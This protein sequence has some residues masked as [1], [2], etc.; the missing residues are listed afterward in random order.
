MTGVEELSAEAAAWAREQPR[1]R[2]AFVVGSQVRSATPADERSD[3]DVVLP[4][5]DPAALVEAPSW[6]ARFGSPEP[7]FVEATAVGG[8]RERCVLY[9]D[10]LEVDFAVFPA[11]AA[12]ALAASP[13]PASAV[14]R[15]YRVLHDEV[16]AAEAL[17]AATDE[18]PPRRAPSEIAHDFWYHAL[19]AAKKHRRGETATARGCLEGRLKPLRVELARELALLRDPRTDTWH[20]ARLL[21]RWADPRAVAASWLAARTPG[22]LPAALHR[23]CDAL[24]AELLP[25]DPGCAGARR[26]LSG[27]LP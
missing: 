16:G 15:G 14:R 13:E 9:A 2:A 12:E 17:A 4:A 21:E 18:P 27:I 24:A 26:R 22:G 10:G 8:E 19:W 7:T 25:P 1:V 20:G 5:D 11:G 6:L 3:V 23:L